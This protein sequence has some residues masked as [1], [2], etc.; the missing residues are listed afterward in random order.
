MPTFLTIRPK[1]RVYFYHANTNYLFE[2]TAE[3]WFSC[4]GTYPW[5]RIE[6]AAGG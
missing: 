4:Y 3:R 6:K 1:L 2:M 5:Q